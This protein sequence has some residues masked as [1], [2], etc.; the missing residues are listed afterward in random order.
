MDYKLYA[1]GSILTYALLEFCFLKNLR[2]PE[3]LRDL[4]FL[5]KCSV[6]AIKNTMLCKLHKVS[7]SLSMDYAFNFSPFCVDLAIFKHP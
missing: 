7:M 1:P 3:I 5:L 6:E 4:K 2:S